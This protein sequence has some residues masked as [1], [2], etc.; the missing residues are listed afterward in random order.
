MT[1]CEVFKLGR[2]GLHVRTAQRTSL[3]QTRLPNGRSTD[4]LAASRAVACGGLWGLK[5]CS[6]LAAPYADACRSMPTL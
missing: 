2:F 5:Q 3:Q 1:T 4:V 6:H